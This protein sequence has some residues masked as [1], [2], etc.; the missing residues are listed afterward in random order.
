MAGKPVA[1]LGDVQ[2]VVGSTPPEGAMGP[3]SWAPN[4]AGPS[5]K[6]YSDLRVGGTEVIYEVSW[7]F[8]Y[9]GGGTPDTVTLSAGDTVLMANEDGVLLHGDSETNEETGNGLF[10][11]ATGH[12][13]S[14]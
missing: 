11:V 2:F 9:S 3:G 10:I 7:Q 12:L 4:P 8:T 13:T 1:V 14:E 6:S 5:Y